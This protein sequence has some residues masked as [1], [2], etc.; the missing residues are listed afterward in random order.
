MAFIEENIQYIYKIAVIFLYSF[1][2][3][4]WGVPFV[5]DKLKKYDY[6]VEDKY[7]PN[8][9]K[10]PSMGGIA[11]FLGMLVS[12]SLSQIL[13][14]KD[15][16]GSLFIF[17]FII[18]VYGL[19]GVVDDLFAFKKRYDK[20]FALLILSLPMASL[21]HDTQLNLFFARYEIGVL[22]SMLIVPVYIM[23]VANMINLHAG[24]NG[25]TQGLSI[26]LLTSIA[27][28]SFMVHQLTYFLYLVP[29]LGAVLAFFPST[30]Y[31]A[32]VLPGNSGDLLVGAAIGSLLVV[33][34]FLW[35]GIWILIPHIIN[36]IMDTYTIVIR[37]LPDVKFGRIRHDGTIE[38]PAT[39]KYKSLKFWI[40]S[41]FRLSEGK[42]VLWLYMIT[43]F[44]CVTGILLF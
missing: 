31:P 18:I 24:Y 35:F 42:A 1:F 23:V 27:V 4:M 16:L 30:S 38:A 40:V 17:Y 12:L 32:K 19:Y 34:G 11:I 26:I 41:V 25:L 3:T 15:N 28:K 36:F 6:T 29:I 33:N 8:K 10:V 39:M 7:K 13:L 44:F 14:S 20:V 43:L 9:A 2:I 5:I 22:Y 21:V 37:R